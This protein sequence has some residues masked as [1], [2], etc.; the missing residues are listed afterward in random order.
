MD[1]N[2]PADALSASFDIVARQDATEADVTALRGDVEEVKARL[3][4]VSRA[5]A[6]PVIGTETTASPEVKGFVD[7]YLRHGRTN[8]LKSIS[9]AVVTDGGYAVTREIDALIARRLTAISP[10]RSIAQVVQTGSAGYRK[11][12]T[13]TGAA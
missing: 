3:D 4:K 10:I 2:V 1:T 8:E 13:T 11:L 9:G 12:S 6:R 5:A 7:G